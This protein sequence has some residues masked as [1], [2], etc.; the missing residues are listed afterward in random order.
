MDQSPFIDQVML[1]N[2]QS[3]YTVAL[4][5]PN[6]IALTQEVK[7][8]GISV[9]S[10]EARNEITKIIQS[11]VNKYKKGGKFEGMFPERWLPAAIGILGEGFTEQNQFLNT[12][13]KMVRGKITD[14]YMT[15]LEYL[16]TSEGKVISNP[17]NDHILSHWESDE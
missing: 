10:V 3:P 5:F 13:L 15:R 7:N 8:K 2:N 4:L 14:F 16:F 1:Y 11:E 12:T 6:K 9:N 17:Q